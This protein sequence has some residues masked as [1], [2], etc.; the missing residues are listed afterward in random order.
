MVVVVVV[1]DVTVVVVVVV[2]DVTVV[3]DVVAVV[4][5]LVVVV[6]VGK[7]NQLSLT[8]VQPAKFWTGC[9][10][11]QLGRAQSWHRYPFPVL[12]SQRPFRVWPTEHT[13]L[14]HGL[15]AAKFV[16][17]EPER[18]TCSSAAHVGAQSKQ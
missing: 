2:V 15:H 10:P 12:L 3:V 11:G 9:E 8:R 16:E 14:S 17:P 5:V 6:V 13:A 18:P 7:Q 4:V 1:V